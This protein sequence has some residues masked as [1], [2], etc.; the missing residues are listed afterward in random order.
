M[1]FILSNAFKAISKEKKI[2]A[3]I[4][5]TLFV[6]YLFFFLGC[7]YVEDGIRDMDSFK[8]KQME[9]SIYYDSSTFSGTKQKVTEEEFDTFWGQYDFV[10]QTTVIEKNHSDDQISGQTQHFYLIPPNYNDFFLFDVSDGRYFTKE[11]MENGARVCVIEKAYQDTNAV[12]VGDFININ[13]TELEVIGVIKRNANGGVIFV[14]NNTIKSGTL[15]KR[16]FQG[17]IIAAQ[18]TNEMRRFDIQ[19]DQLGLS[20]EL[21]T[22]QEYYDNGVRFFLVRSTTVFVI[23][24]VLLFYALLNLINIMVGKLESQKKSLGIRLALGASYRQIFLQ[25]FFECLVLVLIAVCA[26]FLSE[27]AISQIVKPYV[28][29]SFGLYSVAAMLIMS[30]ASSFFISKALLKK[31]KKMDVIK[32]I[33]NL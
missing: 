11:E 33:K 2:N 20:G 6:A 29:H 3:V 21:Y 31:L 32:I 1:K 13:N 27:P 15:Q 30:A 7:C 12:N 23:C 14:P 25:F 4:V 28:N 24:A 22:A 10:E 16:D 26:V 19:W 17:Y 8:L 5:F 9:N 18:L